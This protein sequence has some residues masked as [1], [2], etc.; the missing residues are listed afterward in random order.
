VT[1]WV[2]VPSVKHPSVTALLSVMLALKIITG[3]ETE[4][5]LPIGNSRQ[6]SSNAKV[7]RSDKL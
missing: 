1:I 6:T 4:E 5:D 2:I 7:T 3:K